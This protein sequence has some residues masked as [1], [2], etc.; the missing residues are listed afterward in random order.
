MVLP[1]TTSTLP[2]ASTEERSRVSKTKKTPQRGTFNPGNQCGIKA[3]AISSS[4]AAA[5]ECANYLKKET[6]NIS[7]F[8]Q[9]LLHPKQAH[10]T[11]YGGKLNSPNPL[12]GEINTTH[13][14]SLSLSETHGDTHPHTHTQRSRS[15]RR[16]RRRRRG[17]RRRGRRGRRRRRGK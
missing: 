7:R 9:G 15:P 1:S 2:G 12:V 16:R 6:S 10:G 14:L 3:P 17:R 11:L 4:T 13:T 5:A 8:A